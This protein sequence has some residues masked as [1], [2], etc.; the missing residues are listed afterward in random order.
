MAILSVDCL[1]QRMLSEVAS[2]EGVSSV[3]IGETMLKVAGSSISID[4]N[5]S[6]INMSEIFK[7]L[8]SIE[9]ISCDKKDNVTKLEKKCINILSAYPF[10]VLTETSGD[11]KNIKISGVF[12][13]AGKN[14][15]ILL[16]AITGGDEASF[17]LLNGNIDIVTLNN[18][19]LYTN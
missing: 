15:V 5:Q 3:F 10:E 14:I 4:S 8:T 1:S 2:M 9:I 11:G 17:I 6:A 16:I 7:D 19:L 18:A 12:D 13:K